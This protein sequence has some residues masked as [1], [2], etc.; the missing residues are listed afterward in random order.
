MLNSYSFIVHM[1]KWNVLLGLAYPLCPVHL[2]L[3]VCCASV[4]YICDRCAQ[5][6]DPL[7][8]VSIISQK[9]SYKIY[10]KGTNSKES[11]HC[12]I[13]NIISSSSVHVTLVIH[14][15]FFLQLRKV[16]GPSGSRGFLCCH[17]SCFHGSSSMIVHSAAEPFVAEVTGWNCFRDGSSCR[18]S[19]TGSLSSSRCR[20]IWPCAHPARPARPWTCGTRCLHRKSRPPRSPRS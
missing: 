1:P 10:F 19:R 13:K 5:T 6:G 4:I 17:Y 11:K 7:R 14:L 9:D 16:V 12:Y 15:Y 20:P 3:E 8:S 18:R 2:N